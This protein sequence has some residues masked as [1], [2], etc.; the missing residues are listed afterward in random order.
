M[1]RH[2][3]ITALGLIGPEGASNMDDIRLRLLLR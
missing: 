1:I 3:L 2:P